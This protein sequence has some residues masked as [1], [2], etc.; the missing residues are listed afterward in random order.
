M[1]EAVKEAL[2]GARCLRMDMDTTR[3]KDAHAKILSAFRRGEADVLVG[4]Q[5]VAKGLDF[6]NVTLSC[7]V[8]ADMSLNLPDFR[9]RERTFQLITQVAGR[10]GRAQ[11]PGHV[12]LQTYDPENFCIQLSARQDF[13]AFYLEESKIRR[14][15]LYPPF[16]VIARI[17]VCAPAEEKARDTAEKIARDLDAFLDANGH[18]PD[19]VQMRALE[20]PVKRLRAQ[21]RYQ[22]FLKMYFKADCAAITAK[23]QALAEG[24]SQGVTA[25]LEVNPTS[26]F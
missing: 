18:R 15:S 23:M 6:P 25:E 11:F 13:R 22:V 9:S 10:A 5:M 16:T 17:I 3:K 20:A 4:T 12:I 19:I 2:P 21:Y 14:G 26:L 1:V 7:V 8:A 24:V